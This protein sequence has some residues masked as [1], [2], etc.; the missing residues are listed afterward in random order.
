MTSKPL[1]GELLVEKSLVSQDIVDQALKI[2][3]GGLRKL[4]CIL[5]RMNIISDD[6]LTEVLMIQL[7]IPRRE[8]EERYSPEVEKIFPRY[9]CKR[10][11]VLPL[12][13][14]ENNVLEVA[15]ANPADE[16]AIN[17][18]EDYSGKVIETCLMHRTVI[19]SEIPNRIPLGVKDFF[20]SKTSNFLTKLVVVAAVF[21]AVFLGFY[22]YQYIKKMTEGEI[23]FFDNRTQY[24]NHDL[25]LVIHKTGEVSL[26]GRGAFSDGR[27]KIHFG[28]ID[29][30]QRFV[31]KR[32][33]DFSV[34]QQ[35]WLHWVLGKK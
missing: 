7:D 34:K 10:Y 2:Q 4:G 33:D 23:V 25:T 31:Q 18:L 6:Q 17:D 15:M 20:L 29:H 26:E 24:T 14:K 21:C 9:L 12:R 30:L 32:E 1:L 3:N 13:L 11:R 19:E 35:N 28:E 22:S 16:E 8:I 5:V 27:Y